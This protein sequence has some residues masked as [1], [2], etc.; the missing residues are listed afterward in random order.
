MSGTAIAQSIGFVLSP[1]ISRLYSP[2]DFGIF[3]SFDAVVGIIAAGATLEYTQAIVLPKQKHDALYLVAISC[4]CSLAFGVLTL[5]ACL[6]MPGRMSALIKTSGTWV[7]ILLALAVVV[8][9][10]SMSFQAWCVRVKAFKQTSASQVIRSLFSIGSQVGFGSV[11]A[12]APGLISSSVIGDF[13]GSVNLFLA[14]L[15]E[16]KMLRLGIQWQRMKELAASTGIFPC[17]PQPRM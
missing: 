6:L 17:M 2:S 13:L 3:G 1:V 4:I 15:P 10:F 5:V 7:H 8:S 16:V 12:G 11:K 9:G 14:V